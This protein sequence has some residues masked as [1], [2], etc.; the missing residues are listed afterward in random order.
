MQMGVNGVS[1]I[2]V[3]TPNKLQTALR[4]FEPIPEKLVMSVNGE[5]VGVPCDD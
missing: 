4:E 2:R 3:G 1:I 5:L